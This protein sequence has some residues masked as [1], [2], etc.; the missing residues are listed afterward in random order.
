M[1]I[2]KR[3]IG[4]C[5]Q[6]DEEVTVTILKINGNQVQIAIDAP[7][8]VTVLRGELVGRARETEKDCDES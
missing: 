3:R 4:E 6:I 7:A 2:V 1:L 5:L 8:C